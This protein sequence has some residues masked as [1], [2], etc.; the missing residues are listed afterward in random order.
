MIKLKTHRMPLCNSKDIQQLMD[1]ITNNLSPSDKI[2][3]LK[4]VERVTPKGICQI[5]H[6]M[7]RWYSSNAYSSAKYLLKYQNELKSAMDLSPPIGAYRGF[8]VFRDS[9]LANVQK[10]DI[11]DLPVTRNGGCASFTGK[12]KIANRFSGKSKDK[13]GLIIKLYSP[14]N[15]KT[16]IAPPSKSQKWFNN[17]YRE[18]MGKS[19]RHNEEE[20]ACC[21]ANNGPPDKNSFMRVKIVEVKK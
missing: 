5:L 17:L 11:I 1:I 3:S 20:Y 16:F 19:F 9:E 21:F 14:I 8:K 13:V 18:T 2:E 15:V 12:R 7:R 10:G 4:L 6:S